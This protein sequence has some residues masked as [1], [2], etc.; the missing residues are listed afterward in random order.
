VATI[1]INRFT[2]ADLGSTAARAA[3]RDQLVNYFAGHYNE[4]DEDSQRRLQTNPLRI[5]D[6]KNPNMQSLLD[7]APRLLDYLDKESQTH[8]A[9]LK[10][11]LD[12]LGLPYQVNP[13]LV[14]GLDY[15]NRTVFEWITQQLGAQ[16]TVCAGGRYDSLVEQIGGRP[17]PAMGFAIGLER[18]ILLLSQTPLPV[19]DKTPHAYLIM[20]GPG[21]L[22]QGLRLAESLRDAL[23]HLRLLTHCGGGNFKSQFKRADKSGALVALVLGEEEMAQHQVTLKYLRQE[24][25]QLRVGLAE[26][27]DYL[28][29]LLQF[30]NE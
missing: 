23:P 2:I 16:G 28:K 14:R 7:N 20:A 26:V 6:S 12:E 29:P 30:F 22:Q 4:L 27:V 10:T 1:G 3:Y 21:T 25:P 8:F 19:P 9:T 24:H 13:H 17:T 5:L 15:Y 18:L 11:W